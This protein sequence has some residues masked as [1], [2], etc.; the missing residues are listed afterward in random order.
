MGTDTLE[1][2]LP[3]PV[4]VNSI[5]REKKHN[6]HQGFL[7][8]SVTHIN[9]TQEEEEEFSSTEIEERVLHQ[10]KE[11]NTIETN[12]N[13]IHK[14]FVSLQLI[15]P[16]LKIEEEEEFSSTEIEETDRHQKKRRKK[17]RTRRNKI[18]R[19]KEN[20]VVIFHVEL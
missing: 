7:S 13:N 3:V 16:T 10:N 17:T 6:I 20:D 15:D 8:Q 11:S 14:G 4:P 19:V 9:P 2:T 18:T 12:T 5:K 1:D